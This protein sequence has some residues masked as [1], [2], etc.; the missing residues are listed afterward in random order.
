MSDIHVQTNPDYKL[1]LKDVRHVV[2]LRLYL[3]LIR[4]LNDKDF[5]SR[6]HR[7]Q[8][9]LSNG[10]LVVSSGKKYYTLY[11]LQVKTCDVQ[12]NVTEKDLNI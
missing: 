2:N 9:K 6:F 1:V 3:I 8:Y 11:R 7:R 12:L 5:D 10:S 4:K